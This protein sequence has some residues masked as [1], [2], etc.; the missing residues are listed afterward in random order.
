VLGAAA[1]QRLG[2]DKIAAHRGTQFDGPA[3]Q[4]VFQHRLRVGEHE[5]QCRAL[6][7][8]S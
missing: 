7:R 5:R 8:V 1:A 2:I 6:R 4:Q 3:F